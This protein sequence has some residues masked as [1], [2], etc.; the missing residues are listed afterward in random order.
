M[1]I[2]FKVHCDRGTLLWSDIHIYTHVFIRLLFFFVGW[3]SLITD[4]VR[5]TSERPD[6]TGSG[7]SYTIQQQSIYDELEERTRD[8]AAASWDRKLP[9]SVVHGET[10]KPS[11]WMCHFLTSRLNFNCVVRSRG[12]LRRT[13]R[14]N[15]ACNPP[16]TRSANS[17]TRAA[18]TRSACSAHAVRL[19]MRSVSREPN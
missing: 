1:T 4:V 2:K 12:R 15:S 17:K 11:R 3:Q 18:F 5:T 9:A 14:Q 8:G 16:C 6:G 7:Q 19:R 13:W 10:R